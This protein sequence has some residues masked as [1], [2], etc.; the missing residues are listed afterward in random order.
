MREGRTAFS[1]SWQGYF[2]TLK[3]AL[4]M[5]PQRWEIKIPWLFPDFSLTKTIFPWPVTVSSLQDLW[6]H[7]VFLYVCL[8]LFSILANLCFPILYFKLFQTHNTIIWASNCI[9]LFVL[10]TFAYR[11]QNDKYLITH[12]MLKDVAF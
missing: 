4:I 10:F 11:Y 12:D 2:L 3:R 6:A 5:Y 9:Q 1:S 7:K 8:L